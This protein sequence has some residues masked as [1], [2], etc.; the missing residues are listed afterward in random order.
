VRNEPDWIE[1][2]AGGTLRN[3][4]CSDLVREQARRRGQVG[5]LAGT[6][7]S[8]RRREGGIEQDSQNG[9]GTGRGAL[10]GGLW[11]QYSEFGSAPSDGDLMDEICCS[12][13]TIK[14]DTVPWIIVA[15]NFP[16]QLLPHRAF[17]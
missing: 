16:K 2:A 4:H 7:R 5:Q 11:V 3:V 13:S 17:G 9:S 6:G 1:M 8:R 14:G 10:N 15:T 12:Y